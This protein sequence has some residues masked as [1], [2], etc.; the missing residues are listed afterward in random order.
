MSKNTIFEK[1][2]PIKKHDV[3]MI[4]EIVKSLLPN[5]LKNNL[6]LDIGSARFK[7]E[8]NDLDLFLDEQSVKDYF[9][10]TDTS[11]AKKSLENYFRDKRL[12]TKLIS[13]N[14]HVSI[15]YPTVLSN[16]E[17]MAYAQVDVMVIPNAKKVAEWHQHGL[18]GMYSDPNFRANHLYILLNS[19]GKYLGYKVDAFG[20]VVMRRDNNE[21]VADNRED[22]AKL[23]LNQNATANDL[24][25]VSTV[26]KALEHDVHREDK[27]QQAY[28]DVEKGL[29]VL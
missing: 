4:V 22:A 13:R 28:C 17:D 20:G 29:L 12:R 23:L 10:T 25:S 2:S 18:R 26:M 24:N 19:I 11:S 16:F 9:N 3:K 1:T 5:Q 14:I 21:I 8:S 15:K 6:I 27:L 7:S